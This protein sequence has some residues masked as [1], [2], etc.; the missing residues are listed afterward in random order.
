[1]SSRRSDRSLIRKCCDCPTLCFCMS[2]TA[3]KGFDFV[4][5]VGSK[6]RH[7]LVQKAQLLHKPSGKTSDRFFWRGGRQMN[8]ARSDHI[9]PHVGR[10]RC[11]KGPLRNTK[12]QRPRCCIVAAFL[13]FSFSPPEVFVLTSP[14]AQNWRNSFF[15]SSA[16]SVRSWH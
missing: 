2:P 5:W 13:T 6:S 12:S 3:Q 15:F 16:R 7:T 11:S 4:R 14:A 10:C 1:M 8:T 9:P